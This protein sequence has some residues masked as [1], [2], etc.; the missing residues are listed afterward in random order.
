[1]RVWKLP[2]QQRMCKDFSLIISSALS[3]NDWSKIMH[4]EPEFAFSDWSRTNS[5]VAC[6][7][8]GLN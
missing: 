4:G 2:W 8:W 7:H 3:H 5:S 1:M 6:N